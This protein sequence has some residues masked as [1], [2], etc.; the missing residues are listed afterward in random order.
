MR[1][2]WLAGGV[3]MMVALVA[4][5]AA[6]EFVASPIVVHLGWGIPA[7]GAA[8]TAF[9]APR[10]KFNVGAAT[11]VLAVLVV[12]AGSYVAGK[13][14]IGDSIGVEGTVLAM[15]LAIPVIGVS[16]VCGALLGEWASKGRVNA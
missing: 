11:V 15:V 14:G 9:L 1:T 5:Y 10:S 16:S 2:A 7:I 13:L 3:A 8:V 4:Y 12:G 6:V